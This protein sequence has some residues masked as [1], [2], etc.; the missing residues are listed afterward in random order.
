M[1]MTQTYVRIAPAQRRTLTQRE[2]L[3]RLARLGAVAEPGHRR[4]ECVRVRAADGAVTQVP[5]GWLSYV[6]MREAVRELG[7]SWR[8][9]EDM[10]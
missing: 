2:V 7:I 9:F 8:D 5:R 10:R 6:Q 4:D 1:A 3:R